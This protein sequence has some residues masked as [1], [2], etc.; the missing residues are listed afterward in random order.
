MEK[1]E[2]KGVKMGK[3]ITKILKFEGK[4]EI[5][6]RYAAQTL[7]PLDSVMNCQLTWDPLM[8]LVAPRLPEPR[9]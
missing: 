8:L 6:Y 4:R 3:H 5:A 2:G 9:P 7:S 1:K